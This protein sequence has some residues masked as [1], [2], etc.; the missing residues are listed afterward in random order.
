MEIGSSAG[1]ETMLWIV[2][3]AVCASLAV[4]SASQAHGETF[5]GGDSV[6]TALETTAA[7]TGKATVDTDHRRAGLGLPLDGGRGFAR[8][9]VHGRTVEVGLDERSGAP[10]VEAETLGG[11]DLVEEGPDNRTGLTYAVN[12]RVSLGLSY[13]RVTDESM[14]F[15]VAETGSLRGDYKSHNVFLQARWEF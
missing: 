13:E 12:K 3:V 14:M 2:R 4:A 9:S 15:E 6:A 7:R 1:V 5:E 11:L 10:A 8:P